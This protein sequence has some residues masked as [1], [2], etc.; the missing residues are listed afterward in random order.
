[1]TTPKSQSEHQT[2]PRTGPEIYVHTA[3]G[4]EDPSVRVRVQDWATY[5]GAQLKWNI[6]GTVPRL[7]S[8]HRKAP[9]GGVDLVLRNLFRMTDG[10]PEAHLL[11]RSALGIYELDDGLPWDTGRLAGLGAWWKVPF[12][13][14]RLA[15]RAAIA[16][17]RVIVG[18]EVLADWA[19]QYN[20]D[21]RLIPTC[22]DLAEYDR[23]VDYKV[24]TEPQL[25]W[26]GSA[27]T[28]F[29][30]TRIAPALRQVNQRTGAR[31]LIVGSSAISTDP[32]LAEFS[33]RIPWS[34][35]A[36]RQQLLLADVGL[37]PLSDSVYQQAK[38]GYKLLQY[39]A[40]GLPAVA[41]PVGVNETMLDNGLGLPAGSLDEWAE[42]VVSLLEL[43]VDQRTKVG[44]RANEYVQ[45]MYTYS[46]WEDRWLSAVTP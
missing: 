13:R 16:A 44:H 26:V 20:D 43:G 25:V 36:Q 41:S 38:C 28:E 7:S 39:A 23:K 4:V 21:V 1:M 9:K 29:E 34:L 11:Q 24:G 35:A 27:A 42:Q 37:M 22:I 45:S 31:L 2:N 12:R 18:N 5:A 19:T 46:I 40:A 32:S 15:Q 8:V 14:D 6:G 10:T 30:L 17:D 33:I 3:S